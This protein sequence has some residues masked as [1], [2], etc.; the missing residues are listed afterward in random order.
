MESIIDGLQIL[1]KYGSGDFSAEHDQIWAGP[2]YLEFEDYSE[3]DCKE[4][5]SLFWFFDK[6]F[7][8]WSRLV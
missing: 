4:L 3:A 8:C 6:E 1:L 7:N 5:D 2:D